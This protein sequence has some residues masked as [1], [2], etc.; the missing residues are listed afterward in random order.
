[1][2]TFATLLTI[3]FLIACAILSSGPLILQTDAQTVPLPNFVPKPPKSTEP[4][5]D[6]FAMMVQLQPHEYQSLREDGWY[7]YS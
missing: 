1:M 7:S 2:T 6:E 4:V 3:L 5:S